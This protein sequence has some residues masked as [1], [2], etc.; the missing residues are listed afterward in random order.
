MWEH[1]GTYP[2]VGGVGHDSGSFTP[3]SRQLGPWFNDHELPAE[4]E[5]RE[6][7]QDLARCESACIE[8]QSA[9]AKVKP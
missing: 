4:R 5:T 6:R 7:A 2:I 8:A 1:Y 3:P 9:A